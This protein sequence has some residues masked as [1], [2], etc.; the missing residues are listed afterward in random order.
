MG[1]ASGS[2][3]KT[4]KLW[5]LESGEEI[6]TVKCAEDAIYTITFS[7]N[8]KLLATGSGDKT[9]TVFPYNYPET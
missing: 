5:N 7:P 8:G 9:I 4:A 3:D 2:K 6:S 1:T